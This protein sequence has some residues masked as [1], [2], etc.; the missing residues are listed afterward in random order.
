MGCRPGT[1][2]DGAVRGGAGSPSAGSESTTA[3][4]GSE[5][6]ATTSDISASLGKAVAPFCTSGGS[7]IGMSGD[8]LAQLAGTGNWRE[9]YRFSGST[10]DEVRRWLQQL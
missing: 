4:A 3:I 9:G 7:G 8:T 2:V 1:L 5:P 10:D 6:A